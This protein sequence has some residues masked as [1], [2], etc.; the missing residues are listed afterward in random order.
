MVCIQ[1]LPPKI[2]QDMLNLQH[3]FNQLLTWNLPYILYNDLLH[4]CMFCILQ[5]SLNSLRMFYQSIS[6][7]Y[8]FHLQIRDFVPLIFYNFSFY[9]LFYVY[10]F[11]LSLFSLGEI[12]PCMMYRSL[13][14]LHRSDKIFHMV[15]ILIFPYWKI[16][17]LDI[18]L[19]H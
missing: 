8:M 13:L 16:H 6:H 5:H 11:I 15:R 10:I 14:Y 18:L 19:V 17:F 9:L 4:P 1:F 7:H 3:I 2:H 12:P